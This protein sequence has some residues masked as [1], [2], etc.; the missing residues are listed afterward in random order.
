MYIY[1]YIY[2]YVC[3]FVYMYIKY[4]PLLQSDEDSSSEVRIGAKRTACRAVT[5]RQHPQCCRASKTDR[6]KMTTRRHIA[7]PVKG[8]STT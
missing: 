6:N 8:S 3:V 4:M 2:I 5:S 1:I 7:L